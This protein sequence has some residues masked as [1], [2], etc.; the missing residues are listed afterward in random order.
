MPTKL[1][2]KRILLYLGTNMWWVEEIPE[3]VGKEVAEI[4]VSEMMRIVADEITETETK[5]I[6]E[7]VVE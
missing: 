6:L 7:R 2:R 1:A 5:E 3:I 4:V